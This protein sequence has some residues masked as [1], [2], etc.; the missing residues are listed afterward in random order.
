VVP[1]ID[2]RNEWP[3]SDAYVNGVHKSKQRL[4]G[5]QAHDGRTPL[6]EILCQ[7]CREG[8]PLARGN[9]CDRFEHAT[10]QRLRAAICQGAFQIGCHSLLDARE[11]SDGTSRKRQWLSVSD[12]ERRQDPAERAARCSWNSAK[13]ELA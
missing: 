10:D 13:V 1:G 9:R 7:P 12:L 3:V 8:A 2:H 5:V 11:G 6:F 4:P